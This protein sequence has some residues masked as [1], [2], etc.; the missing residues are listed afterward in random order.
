MGL[1]LLSACKGPD[2]VKVKGTPTLKS[3]HARPSTPIPPT[4]RD[5]GLIG[6]WETGCVNKS[7]FMKKYYYQT[8][9]K[10]YDNKLNTKITYH[11]IG[12][13][14]SEACLPA[15]TA[16]TAKFETSIVLGTTT[17]PKTKDEH[18]D[19]N[20]TTTK[21]QLVPMNKLYVKKFNDP[22]WKAG[23]YSGLERTDWALDKWKDVTELP[24]AVIAFNIEKS[25][26]DIFQVSKNPKT[27]NRTL[28]MGD[29][30]GFLD[31]T[32]RP[33]TLDSNEDTVALFKHP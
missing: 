2:E 28:K 8:T 33:K 17:D 12:V 7:T 27:M 3:A 31:K 9:F 14:G 19:I 32:G 30:Q 6:T 4:P 29:M 16:F 24:Q 13:T 25:M 21:V 22:K 20:I 18:T 10:F 26:P 5:A 1:L 15:S 11:R 23:V